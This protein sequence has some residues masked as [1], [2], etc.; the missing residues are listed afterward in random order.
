MLKKYLKH[1]PPYSPAIMIECE[2]GD[3]V[4]YDD[5]SELYMA[6][7][8]VADWDWD[9]IYQTVEGSDGLDDLKRLV[10]AIEKINAV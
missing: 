10:A 4:K 6:A 9:A 1:T 5:I 8:E 7:G 3:W 2:D